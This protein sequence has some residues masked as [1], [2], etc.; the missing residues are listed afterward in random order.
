MN[1][2]RLLFLALGFL[3]S[4]G[5]AL[6]QFELKSGNF[7]SIFVAQTAAGD[8]AAPSG[9][10]LVTDPPPT[11]S[12][13]AA[14]G[15]I[16]GGIGPI[17]NTATYGDRYPGNPAKTLILAQ[18]TIGGVFAS[19]LPRFALGDVI[20]PPLTQ[21]NGVTAAEPDYWRLQPVQAGEIFRIGGASQTL[22]PLASVTVSSAASN[23]T[24]VTVAGTLPPELAVGATLLGQPIT[25]ISGNNVTLAGN[26]NASITSATAVQVT[27]ALSYYYSPHAEKVF[28]S[29]AGRVTVTWITRAPDGSG[30]HFT[31][32]EDF[33]VSSNTA[34]P[35]RTIYWTEGGFD[36]PRVQ[37][38]DA[39]IT[40]VNPVYYSA[41]PKATP[42][43]VDIP[44]NVPLTPNLSTLS[45]DR[46]GGIGQ[47]RAYNV[48]GRIL[49]E[50]LGAIRK[51]GNI[52]EFIGSDVVEIIRTPEANY[53]TVHLGKEISPHEPS[54]SF[55]PAPLGGTTAQ[56]TATLA[57]GKVTGIS[58]ISGG[59]GYGRNAPVITFAI[60]TAGTAATASATV[61]NGVVTSVTLHQGGSGYPVLKPAPVLSNS[62]NGGSHYGSI[63][64]PDA[65]TTYFA[66]RETSAENFPDDGF[67]ASQDAFNK[68]VFYWLEEGNFSIQWPKFQNRYWLRWSPN[69]DEYVHHT[70]D[71]SGSTADTGMPFTG[72]TLP[73]IVHQ[74]DP[75]Q[76]EASIN[77]T[78]Q[79]LVVRFV[80]DSDQRNR[81]LLKFN[82]SSSVWYVNLYSQTENRA[83][84][85]VSTASPGVSD[86]SFVTVASTAGL[87]VGMVV[88]GPGITGSAIITRIINGTSIAISQVIAAATNVLR[89]TVESDAAA[90]INAAATVGSRLVQPAGHENAGYIS[91]GTGYFPQGYLNPFTVGV[92]AA[93]KGAIIPVNA[94]P[95][96]KLITVRWFKKVSAPSAQFSDLYVPGKIGRYTVSYP[97]TTSP[98]IVIAQGVGTG[99]LSGAEQA[100]SVYY[101]NDPSAV[102]YNP[103]EEHSLPLAPRVY[104][105]RDDLNVTS[106]SGYTSEPFV[107]LSYTDQ[108]DGRPAIRA[109]KVIRSNATFDFDFVATAGTLL[110]KPYPLPLMPLPMV[111][112]GIDRTSKDVELTFDNVP[113]NGTVATED[114][115]K[116][117]TFK[118]RKGF[119]WVHRGPHSTET[120][121]L[122]MKLYYLSRAGFFVPGMDTLPVGTVLPFLR[123]AGRSGQTLNIN[124]INSNEDGRP[125]GVDEPLTVTYRPTWPTD[126]PELRVAETLTLPKFG[127]PQVRGQASAEVFYQQS[128]ANAPTATLRT[129]NSVTLHDPTREKTVALGS[130]GVDLTALPAELKTTSYQG[131]TYFQGLPPHL[132]QRLYLDPVRGSKGALVFTGVFHDAIAGEDYLDLN[133]LTSS[134][135][136]AVKGLVPAAALGEAEAKAKAN[137]DSAIDELKTKVETF[138]PDI[139]RSGSYTVDTTQEVSGTSLAVISSPL[140]AVDSY[141]LTATGQGSGFVTMVFGNS[142]NPKQQPEGDPVQ[143]KVFK[144]ANQL[145]V[146]DLKVLQSSNP[147]DEQVTLR[148]SGDFAGKPEDYQFEWRWH[149]GAAS[150]PSI[151][152]TVMTR[153]L[154]DPASNTHRWLVVRD[155][156]SLIP[157]VSQYAAA[158]S[159]LPFSRSENVYPVNYVLDAQNRPT[160]TVIEAT[161]YTA[162]EIAAGYPSLV[163][164]SATGVDFTTG[165]PNDIVFSATLGNFDGFALYVNGRV[166]VAHNVP[167]TY[168]TPI[169]AS[170]GLSPTGLLKQFSI[171]AGYFTAGMNT[172]EVAVYTSADPNSVSSLNF[173]LEAALETDVVVTEDAWQKPTTNPEQ[174]TNVA[175]VTSSK[176]LPFGGPQFVINDRWFTMRYRPLLTTANVLTAGKTTQDEVAWSRW[177]PPQFVEG[178]IKRVLAAINPFEQRMKD[179][180]NNAANTDVSVLTQAG[181]R[182]EGDVA[183]TMS[184]INDVGLIAIYETVLNRGKDMS[185]NANTSDSDTN[186]ALLLAA[187][188]LNDL[189]TI[190]GN[191][192]F[193]DAANP[194]ISLDDQTAVTEVNTS[195]F[196]F[197]GQVSSSLEEELAMLRGRD[198]FTTT[199]SVAP[200]Y[201][202]LYWNY[203]RGINS[204]EVIYA[205]NYNV[206]EKV[207]SSTANGVIDESDAQRMFPQGHGDAYGHYLT[208]LTGYYR[209]LSNKNFTWEPSAETVTVLGQPVTVDYKDERKFAASAAN[210]ARTAEQIC[211]LVYRQSYKDDSAAGWGSFRDSKGL[212]T[213]TG[214]TSRQGLDEW[215]SRS[216]QGAY[217]HWAVANALVPDVDNFNTGVQKIDRTTVPEIKLL[218]SV[219]TSLQSTMDNANAHLNPLGLS[220]G[221][222]AF[223][224][225]SAAL[226]AGQSQFEQVYDRSLL[227]LTNASGAFNQASRMTRSLRNQQN[228]ID[229]YNTVIVQ[230]ERA[231][232]SQLIDIFGRPYSGDVGAG[233]TYVQGYVGPDTERW[234]IVDRPSRLVENIS[235]ESVTMRVPHGVRGFTGHSISDVVDSYNNTVDTLQR[236]LTIVPNRFVQFA[237][238]ILATGSRPQ[239]GALQDALLDSHLAQVALLKACHEWKSKDSNFFRQAA[240]FQNIV[241]IHRKQ[242][243]NAKENDSKVKSLENAAIALTKVSELINLHTDNALKIAGAAAE[244][245]PTSVGLSNDVT[246]PARGSIKMWNAIYGYGARLVGYSLTAGAAG[247]QAR[248][249]S[250][251]KELERSLREMDLS[252][253]E[254]QLAYE[255]EVAYRD[256]LGQHYQLAE[257]VATQQ[258]ADQKAVNIRAQGDTILSEREIFRQRAAAIIQG[259]RTKDLGF[260]IFRNEA[261]EQ[262][263]SLFDLASRYTYLAAKSYDYETG[264]LGTPAGQDVFDKIIASRSLGDLTGGVPQST[265]STLGDAGLAGT[266]AQLKADFSVAEGRLGINNPDQYGTVFSL[267]AELYRLLN[268]PNISSDDRAWQQTLEQRMVPNL[269]N[270]ADVATY[271]R[272]IKKADGTPVP[273]IIIPFSTTIEHGKNFFGLPL[274]AGD[275]NYTPTNFATKIFN[276]G[277]ALPG[278]VGMD[279]FASGTP[280]A[281]PP[282]SGAANALSATPYAYLIP[283]GTDYMLAPP[284]G[285]TNTLRA[286]SVKDQAIPLPYN[287]GASSFN[288]TQFFSAN[289][290]LSEQPWILRKHQS[291]RMVED[292]ALFYSRVPV[293]FTNS[294]LIARSVWNSQWKIV[295]PAYT[296]SSNEQEGLNRFAASVKDIHLFLRTYSNSGN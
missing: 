216:T 74:D 188:Y 56:A 29:Q 198:D 208:A 211:S 246:A 97:A 257:L 296:L 293:E 95:N 184:N 229:D 1:P 125:G 93:N 223:D 264:L 267:R 217:L 55:S 81:S 209:L 180:Y 35:V 33:A 66:E 270:D 278:Y 158:G 276:V 128:I 65:A 75:S 20:T 4:A 142:G 121:T 222:I 179:L 108:A 46:F 38:T 133:L 49:I 136:L 244:M 248:A 218:A 99:D 213:Q 239:T 260:R 245:L 68:V 25:R 249:G 22:F 36:G 91:G 182:W 109:Y 114:A 205:V 141:A 64:G 32:E 210:V 289:G 268:D 167:S 61:V 102:G 252:L 11:A 190:L 274:A 206:K 144:V 261:L 241:A 172:I 242:L 117:F 135:L 41:V 263:R 181:T 139:A 262:Y 280:T 37:I 42:Q 254:R 225:S 94:L 21:A 132:Q 30:N 230:Q 44:G 79:R 63:V 51:A 253:E 98:Q 281:G 156:G 80:P 110:V 247:A 203:T 138:K 54:V 169:N 40:T 107:L 157:S 168:F 256:L 220:S 197:E 219:G 186:N 275:H 122:R 237:D 143:V 221:A 3:S 195:R 215:V 92:E 235:A 72:G 16:A 8:A 207:G 148:H 115:Y 243:V 201:N 228:Q 78:T 233:K 7:N 77:L 31:K 58:I 85:L 191:E 47:L 27:P 202:R 89:Y 164:K 48:E 118:D 147:L 19:G 69:L 90:P 59:S 24:T 273:G 39:R 163:A 119:T 236:T 152:S 170:T 185:I 286:W 175:L 171:A 279:T 104:A 155:P 295:I 146:G 23:L 45:F 134:E 193:A 28:A 258:R 112:T 154:G 15:Q 187:G 232:V 265:A 192:A 194:T 226:Q 60:P 287:L 162:A 126:A 13:F 106:G 151:Y 183:L 240:E 34:R 150:A 250:L 87:E 269:L 129:K 282:A 292:A 238:V 124:A 73:S 288:G 10:P 204:G 266:M 291:F 101:Q 57:N 159:A 71:P 82:G 224:L 290:T 9:P 130:T 86:V 140:T 255:L 123:A 12:Q 200:A 113:F 83:A 161:S 160:S 251:E 53:Q 189:Y 131:K 120:A 67:P 196:S 259:Y 62:Q 100:G 271:C 234:F 84:L 149:T 283:C 173:M 166:A 199:A 277:I 231:Y 284:L 212:N 176:D 2:S 70:V 285:D 127:L 178:W 76:S 88:S 43:E 5:S 14:M 96:D 26:A 103:N 145:Y 17:S 105:L 52:H 227:A 294:R 111:G 50:Y 214:V 165:V 272:N 177:M 137:W 18:A 116:G 153:R 174:N 6:A